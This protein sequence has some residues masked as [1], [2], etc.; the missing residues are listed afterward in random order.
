VTT[1]SMLGLCLALLGATLGLAMAQTST[2]PACC[3]PNRAKAAVAAKRLALS[4]AQC[5][6]LAT[7]ERQWHKA[8]TGRTPC[9]Q[10]RWGTQKGQ[11]LEKARTLRQA[12]ATGTAETK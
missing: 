1:R 12:P 11:M 3:A 7:K 8:M 4:P 10:A 9:P 2:T 6:L 5:K